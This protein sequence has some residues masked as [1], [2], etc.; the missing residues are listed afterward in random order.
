M[1]RFAVAALATLLGAACARSPRPAWTVRKRTVEMPVALTSDAP[2]E[3]W[4]VSIA[5]NDPAAAT[6]DGLAARGELFVR[7]R[8]EPIDGG[9]STAGASVASK[10][11]RWGAATKVVAS[12]GRPGLLTL[13]APFDTVRCGAPCVLEC[14]LDLS[15]ED[16]PG[17][18]G[19]FELEADLYG[20]RVPSDR[21]APGPTPGI[22]ITAQRSPP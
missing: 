14:G 12:P 7:A 11:G 5:L 19:T 13:Y 22:W 6:I 1:T 21:V 2:L 9:A 3:R 10:D 8:L 4:T 15:L 18:T 16:G 17:V 20:P